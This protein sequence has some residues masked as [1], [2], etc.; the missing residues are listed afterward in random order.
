[1]K[2]EI[3][4]PWPLRI[5]PYEVL[6]PGGPLLLRIAREHALQGDADALDIVYGAPTLAIKKV[7]ANDA[8]GVHMRMPRYWVCIIFYEDDFWGL[9]AWSIS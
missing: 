7:E 9:R 3:D 6:I 2:Y 1:M 5:V 4:I 8:V